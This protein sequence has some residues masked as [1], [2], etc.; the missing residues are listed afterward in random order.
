MRGVAHLV[1][2]RELLMRMRERGKSLAA[3][4]RDTGI[5]R[6][7][8]SRWWQRYREQGRAGLQPRSRRPERSPNRLAVAIEQEILQLRGRGWGPARIAAILHIGH[9]SVHRVL[10]IRGRNRLRRPQPRVS[11]RY[12]KSRPGELLHLDLK[13]LYR[14][15][16]CSREFA[17]AAVDDFSR[18]AVASIRPKRSS[19]DA[20]SFLEHVVETLPYRVESVMTDNDLIFTMRHAY[21]PDRKTRFQQACK[22]LGIAHWLTK[23]L[24]PQ[25]NGKVE[26]F[27]R[28]LDDECFLIRNPGCSELRIKDLAEF[29]WYYNHQRPHLSLLGLTPIERRQAYFQQA[30]V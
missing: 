23:P 28:T 1:Q 9:S 22:S 18:E 20:A 30:P 7:V 17:Y 6:A 3:I 2:E 24:H 4:S 14:W 8:L 10:A 5:A 13:Y 29:V 25:S 21:N 19:P 12:E 26:R 27:F 16:N 15:R 11:H